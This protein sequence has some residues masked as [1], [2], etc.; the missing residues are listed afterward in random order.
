MMRGWQ[1]KLGAKSCNGRNK[2][3]YYCRV[4]KLSYRHEDLTMGSVIFVHGTGVRRK[5]FDETYGVIRA[6]IAELRPELEVRPC[7]W[8]AE[9]GTRLRAGGASIPGYMESGGKGIQS[10][11]DETDEE[12]LLWSLLYYD[13]LY[14]LR[15]LA[16]CQ[17]KTPSNTFDAPPWEELQNK[18]GG[19]EIGSAL[20]SLLKASAL[21]NV[22]PEAYRI[23]SESGECTE[24]LAT[25]STS[26]NE[27]RAA[28][29]RAVVA[30]AVV[31]A[32]D[33]GAPSPDGALRDRLVD[34]IIDQLGK[35]ERGI[36][37]WFTRQAATLAKKWLSSKGEETRGELS[38]R[39]FAA[40]G[41][42]LLYQTRGEKVRDFIR[43]EIDKAPE[44]VVLLAHS[45]GG[46]ACVDLLALASIPKVTG[47]I[48][49]GSQAP[50]LYELDTLVS[51]RFPNPLPSYFPEWLNFYDR[52]DFLSYKAAGVFKTRVKDQ[53]VAS[54]QPFPESHS[55]YWTNPRVWRHAEPYL[56]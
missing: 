15:L 50:F 51:V 18:I 14:E 21:A 5:S 25:I 47:L 26:E 46:I 43:S 13:P 9:C 42:V 31:M 32:R 38:D 44:P 4:V 56:P 39:G 22:F 10:G 45:L 33:L 36:T 52:H 19:F 20:D 48:T 29:A 27:H 34:Q 54:R 3:E 12:V 55:A 23:V 53:E 8:G 11:G 2:C 37:S 49:A 7:F 6:K 16:T 28:F 30:E 40:A 41:D 24:A 1:C 17:A 35:G